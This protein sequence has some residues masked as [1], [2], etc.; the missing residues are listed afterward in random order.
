M[1]LG[2]PREADSP[3]YASL[4]NALKW[5]LMSSALSLQAGHLGCEDPHKEWDNTDY[6]YEDLKEEM[7]LP[8]PPAKPEENKTK[9]VDMLRDTDCTEETCKYS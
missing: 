4:R 1:P 3:S 6:L 9:G 8:P 7:P 2:R 5:V